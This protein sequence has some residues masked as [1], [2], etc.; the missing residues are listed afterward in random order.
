[1]TLQV[2]HDNALNILQCNKL[3]LYVLSNFEFAGERPKEIGNL[4]SLE[5]LFMA[6]NMLLGSMSTEIYNMSK[7]REIG[8]GNNSLSGA[9][10]KCICDQLLE[11]ES[12][13]LHRNNLDGQLPE[14]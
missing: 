3:S 4:Q 5:S 12:L 9:L 14:N 8:F 13:Y 2:P 11:L 10:P 7:L 6:N 1:M